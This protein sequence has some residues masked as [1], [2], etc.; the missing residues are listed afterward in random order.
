MLQETNAPTRLHLFQAGDRITLS[1]VPGPIRLRW[2]LTTR[3]IRQ[4]WFG[5]L[6]RWRGHFYRNDWCR[7]EKISTLV[8][9]V[10]TAE[11]D[12]SCRQISTKANHILCWYSCKYSGV[13]NII[14]NE[15]CNDSV[16]ISINIS[17]HLKKKFICSITLV[18]FW[19]CYHKTREWF[20]TR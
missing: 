13:S 14:S 10:M 20:W 8:W 9:T 19:I 2:R 6:I 12:C 1:P 16:K 15:I 3:N 7:S 11:S 5:T 18:T 17:P 4:S